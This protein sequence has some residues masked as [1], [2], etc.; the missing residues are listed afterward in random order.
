MNKITLA[1]IVLLAVMVLAY[2][3]F[4]KRSPSANPEL[5]D[6]DAIVKNIN[7]AA[8]NGTL[9][10]KSR[11]AIPDKLGMPTYAYAYSN[12]DGVILKYSYGD[13]TNNSVT[14]ANYYYDNG[15]LRYL[16]FDGNSSIGANLEHKIYFSADGAMLS[17]DRQAT[18]T[19][20]PWPQPA[21]V[22]DPAK[23]FDKW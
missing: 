3:F 1:V 13:A 7:A 10:R 18:G 8:E 11:E 5:V 2:M 21:I 4:G 16:S 12:K 9:T 19:Q 14:N 20:F 23:D 17:E 6:I 15:K 22:N